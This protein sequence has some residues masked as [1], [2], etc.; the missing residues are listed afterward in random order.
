M[1]DQTRFASIERCAKSYYLTPVVLSAIDL[2]RKKTYHLITKAQLNPTAARDDK[3]KRAAEI[4]QT[5]ASDG[6]CG[7]AYATLCYRGMVLDSDEWLKRNAVLRPT[8]LFAVTPSKEG[9][10]NYSRKIGAKKQKHRVLF[11]FAVPARFPLAV[12]QLRIES[13]VSGAVEWPM[14]ATA[15]EQ[16]KRESTWRYLENC[17]FLIAAGT[18]WIVYSVEQVHDEFAD[19]DGPLNVVLLKV[20]V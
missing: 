12:I 7:L 3:Y 10:R 18:A 2:W 6:R 1:H 15:Y 19:D 14:Q 5:L 11:V 16:V 20:R 9:A 17:E 13:E 8:S 4:L